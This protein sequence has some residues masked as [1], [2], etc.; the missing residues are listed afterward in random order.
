MYMDLYEL[1]AKMARQYHAVSRGAGRD[2][3]LGFKTD[4]VESINTDSPGTAALLLHPFR[5]ACCQEQ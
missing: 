3:G 5:Q 1:V 2:P 4:A